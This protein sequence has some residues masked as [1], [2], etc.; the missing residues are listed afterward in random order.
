[1]ALKVENKL[2]AIEPAREI[3]R[4]QRR[5]KIYDAICWIVLG[6]VLLF[7]IIFWLLKRLLPDLLQL[8]GFSIHSPLPWW[9]RTLAATALIAGFIYLFKKRRGTRIRPNQ[10]FLD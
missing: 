7:A 8:V 10:K 5:E 3:W 6:P 4:K 9:I 1:M 2:K